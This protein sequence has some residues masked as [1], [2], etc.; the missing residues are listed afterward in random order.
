[1][2]GRLIQLTFHVV[3]ILVRS[4]REHKVFL[5]YKLDWPT[6][7]RRVAQSAYETLRRY[8][9][10]VMASGGERRNGADITHP[11]IIEKMPNH[12][13]QSSTPMAQAQKREASD[14]KAAIRACAALA[15]RSKLH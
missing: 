5:E 7:I 15:L 8:A 11:A 9:P 14:M 13:R 2:K 6:Q 1:M 4:Y 12:I 10:Y 3:R